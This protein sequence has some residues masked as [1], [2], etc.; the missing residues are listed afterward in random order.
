MTPSK[1]KINVQIT[2]WTMN[3]WVW[4]LHCTLVQIVVLASD[5]ETIKENKKRSNKRTPMRPDAAPTCAC[6]GVVL[7][8]VFTCEVGIITWLFGSACCTTICLGVAAM[9]SCCCCCCCSS[10]CSIWL[11][12]IIAAFSSFTT[13][14]TSSGLGWILFSSSSSSSIQSAARSAYNFAAVDDTVAFSPSSS[15]SSDFTLDARDSLVAIVGSGSGVLVPLEY[16]V[17][18]LSTSSDK[19]LVL[20]FSPLGASIR[21]VSQAASGGTSSET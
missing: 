16:F 5:V 8:F 11:L 12:T 19:S 2:N 17:F 6:E 1:S 21:A 9:I 4:C 7:T 20:R 10:C 15:C 18:L 3:E 14:G 13:T